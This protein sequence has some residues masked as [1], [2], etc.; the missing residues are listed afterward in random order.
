MKWLPAMPFALSFLGTAHALD[1][2]QLRE[3][4]ITVLEMCR[5][6]TIAGSSSKYDVQANAQ[7]SLVVLKG[8]GEAGADAKVQLSKEQWEGIRALANPENYSKCVKDT[9]DT[10]VGALDNQKS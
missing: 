10:L 7:G 8:V 4:R 9:L 6:G 2:A 3:L 1:I 5:G